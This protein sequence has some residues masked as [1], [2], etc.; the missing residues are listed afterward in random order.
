M[1]YQIE[2]KALVTAC[3]RALLGREPENQE[4]VD[5]RAAN[6]ETPEAVIQSFLESDEFKRRYHEANA[7]INLADN[8]LYDQLDIDLDVSPDQ[9][10]RM[11]ARI[12]EEWKT[13][14]ET[15]PHWSVLTWD[16]FHGDQLEANLEAFYATGKP[17]VE[18]M[19][20]LA[21]RNGY[22][23]GTG[24]TCLELGCGV[25]RVTLP[26]SDVFDRVHGFDISPGNLAEAGAAIKARGVDNIALTQL[27]SIQ[28][29][30]DIPEYDV[31]FTVIVLQHNPPPIQTYVLDALLS[32]VRAGGAAY[33]Q[34]PTY[35]PHYRFD[36]D[37]YLASPSGG[38]EMHAVPM[39][40]VLGMLRDHG[41]E[42]REVVQ[43][44][45]TALPGSHSFFA[46]K[47][48]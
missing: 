7:Q 4:V 13:L 45:F 30:A 27:H 18:W 34:L 1:S 16:E 38:M 32:K 41:F 3:Y 28:E 36:V 43:D 37:E 44:N 12:Q 33:F 31:L 39:Q 2:A 35:L 6:V 26:L 29:I 5:D 14:G 25:G 8:Y 48:G 40:K 24:Q 9:L 23:M 21:R 46:V 19:Q 47:T 11:F 15:E 10:A 22:E 17:N 42:L 20:N